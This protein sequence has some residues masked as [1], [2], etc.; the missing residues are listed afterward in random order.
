MRVLDTTH[1]V[2]A[3][4]SAFASNG[5][6][7]HGDHAYVQRRR[8]RR[9]LGLAGKIV[10]F[11][12]LPRTSVR[13]LVHGVLQ[14]DSVAVLHGK[15]GS[16]K[17]FVALDLAG[18]VANGLPWAG[19]PTQRG[20]AFYLV[21]EG[22]SGLFQRGRA[23]ELEHGES[24]AG[25]RFLP[26]PVDFLD[27][28]AVDELSDAVSG[29]DPSPDLIVVDTLARCLVGDENTAADMSRFV[30]ACD[31]LRTLTGAC[32]LV[33]HHNNRD[34]GYRGSNVLPANATTRIEAKAKG[35]DGRVE[36]QCHKQRDGVEF[37]LI[38]FRRVVHEVGA[39]DATGQRV[40]SLA[41]R[42]ADA[43]DR[44]RRDAATLRP[45]RRA[46]LDALQELGTAT[47]T[48]WERACHGAMAPRTFYRALTDLVRDRWV[49]ESDDGTYA[50]AAEGLSRQ[51]QWQ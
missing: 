2:K 38:A 11:D 35:K 19:R 18:C 45:T 29:L 22:D 20:A 40:T 30:A 9:S 44:E 21:A 4:P 3:D 24:L 7:P 43:G 25:V 12:A 33:I 42:P 49:E 46:A 50:L 14:R 51:R 17:T 8:Q 32:V 41:M 34:G 6:G 27:G 5:S 26:T 10:R 16:G 48:N 39:R 13:W 23:W 28:D 1:E 36:L 15:E 31:R 37:P 47:A